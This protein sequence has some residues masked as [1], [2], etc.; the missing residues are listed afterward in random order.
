MEVVGDYS[1]EWELITSSYDFLEGFVIRTSQ[2]R[3]VVVEMTEYLGTTLDCIGAQV[4][5]IRK[6]LVTQDNE[7][8]LRSKRYSVHWWYI[9][10]LIAT[11]MDTAKTCTNAIAWPSN[12]I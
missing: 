3:R 12:G 8:T 9:T 4:A 11:Q 2:F 10:S 7:T 6:A 5:E 1:D